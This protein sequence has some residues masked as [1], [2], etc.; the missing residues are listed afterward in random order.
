MRE[1]LSD[2]PALG[3]TEFWNT[4]LLGNI[5]QETEEKAADGGGLV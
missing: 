1:K 5:E 2:V 3:D 4:G